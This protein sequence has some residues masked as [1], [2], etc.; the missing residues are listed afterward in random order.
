MLGLIVAQCWDTYLRVFGYPVTQHVEDP[1]GGCRGDNGLLPRPLPEGGPT[2]LSSYREAAQWWRLLD[3]SRVAGASCGY[4][5]GGGRG[6]AAASVNEV[7]SDG[8]K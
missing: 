5:E 2:P 1:H 6:G 4:G 8:F 7:N 3:V